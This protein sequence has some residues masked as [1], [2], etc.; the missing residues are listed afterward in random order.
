MRRTIA[1]ALP[2]C[3]QPITRK[4]PR[5]RGTPSAAF[6]RPPRPRWL[7]PAPGK[8]FTRPPLPLDRA[9]CAS[10]STAK[11]YPT[12]KPI[13]KSRST[14]TYGPE[15]PNNIYPCRAQSA[16]GR[17]GKLGRPFLPR[18]PH[19]RI[20]GPSKRR[21]RRHYVYPDSPSGNHLPSAPSLEPQ[22][23][24]RRPGVPSGIEC[25]QVHCVPFGSLFVRKC[26]GGF[27]AVAPGGMRTGGGLPTMSRNG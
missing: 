7:T 11:P 22:F 10:R 6:R 18:G 9:A 27:R 25:M 8:P 15:P 3:Q 16:T 5:A 17:P 14:R 24:T 1:K 12:P 23:T 26:T 13:R 4:D 2:D 19:Q 21:P 20:R